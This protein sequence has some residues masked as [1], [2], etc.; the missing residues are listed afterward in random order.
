MDLHALTITLLV[1]AFF[2]VLWRLREINPPA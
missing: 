1:E 2:F